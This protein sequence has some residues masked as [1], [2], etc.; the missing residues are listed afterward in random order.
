MVFWKLYYIDG[1]IVHHCRRCIWNYLSHSILTLSY[2]SDADVV[3][4][5][6]FCDRWI[7]ILLETVNMVARFGRWISPWSI[8]TTQKG[9]LCYKNRCLHGCCIKWVP[10]SPGYKQPCL[11]LPS[12]Q[13]P[14][15]NATYLFFI[16][17]YIEIF[18]E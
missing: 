2:E 9:F 13:L 5:I 11:S 16:L 4:V 14:L 6:C 15:I 10:Q 1:V 18:I 8:T 7:V 17:G 12:V 3:A